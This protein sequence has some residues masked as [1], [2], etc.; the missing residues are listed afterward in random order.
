MDDCDKTSKLSGMEWGFH[1][2][3]IAWASLQKDCKDMKL[4]A[5]YVTLTLNVYEN[6]SLPANMSKKKETKINY[7]NWYLIPIFGCNESSLE[8]KLPSQRWESGET[9]TLEF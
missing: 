8:M 6:S 4:Q 7:G 5:F 3:E 9:S 1:F 2:N